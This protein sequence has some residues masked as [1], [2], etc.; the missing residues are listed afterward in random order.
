MYVCV[1]MYVCLYVCMYAR[2]YVCMYVCMHVRAYIEVCMHVRAYVRKT[3]LQTLI[4]VPTN[5]LSQSIS[6][7]DL[8][9]NQNTT[10]IIP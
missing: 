8:Q 5:L 4:Q 1:C 10:Q 7:M 2:M 3:H 9:N 6:Y